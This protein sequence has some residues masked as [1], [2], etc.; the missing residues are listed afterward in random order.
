MEEHCSEKKKT[1]K[2]ETLAGGI[3][4]YFG[5]LNAFHRILDNVWSVLPD[6]HTVRLQL[7][8]DGPPLFKSTSTQFWPIL[9]MLQEYSKNPVV[10]G[11]FV[12]ILNLSLC[13]NICSIWLMK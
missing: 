11:L 9:G 7:N 4:H 10:I 3:F 1:N 13:R 12:V 6:R 5:I 2:I 8:F